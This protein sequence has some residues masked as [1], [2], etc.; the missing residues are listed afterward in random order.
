MLKKGTFFYVLMFL[1]LYSCVT[2]NIYFP[3]KEAQKKASEIVNEIRG[4]KSVNDNL[5][6]Q[7][8]NFS[9]IHQAYAAG[10][11][12][13]VTNTKIETI[14][15]AMKNRFK[16]METYY[17][18]GYLAEQSNGYLK[19][20]RNPSSLKDKIKLKKLVKAENNDR[21]ML[22]QEVA[23]ILHIQSSQMNKLKGI[24]AKQWKET[25]PQGTYIQTK[26]GWIRKK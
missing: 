26:T 7:S 15:Q 20:F 16:L 25:A 17:R 10:S 21:N 8:Y 11:A 4:E 18:S 5:K 19:I 24:F 9:F 3:S 12:L 23:K 1:F 22:Y 14:K 13:E 2:V 6:P